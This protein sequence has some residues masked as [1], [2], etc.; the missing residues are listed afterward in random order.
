VKHF[1]LVGLTSTARYFL[2]KRDIERS[3]TGAKPVIRVE[4]AKALDAECVSINEFIFEMK[5]QCIST[6]GN[7]HWR[8]MDIRYAY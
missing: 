3:E 1:K 8:E 4:G 5:I 2:R 6:I 7:E